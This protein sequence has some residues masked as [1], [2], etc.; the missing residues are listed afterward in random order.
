MRV[1]ALRSIFVGVSSTMTSCL[2]ALVYFS[3]LM[4]WIEV[5]CHQLIWSFCESTLS[6]TTGAFSF[7][8]ALSPQLS[9]W[10]FRMASCSDW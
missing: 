7:S 8:M 4:T 9:S 3:S 1:D 2:T 5:S 10:T 6:G